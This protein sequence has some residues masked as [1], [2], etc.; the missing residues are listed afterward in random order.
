MSIRVTHCAIIGIALLLGGCAYSDDLFGTNWSG[1]RASPTNATTGQITNSASSSQART[2]SPS[3]RSA[4]ATT[5]TG[6]IVGEQAQRLRSDLSRLEP[7]VAQRQQDLTAARATVK[8]DSQAY[9][10]TVTRVASRVKGGTTPGNPNLVAQWTQAQSSLNHLIGDIDQLSRLSNQVAADISF[11]T[12]LTKTTNNAFSLQGAVEEDH[13]QLTAI[14][15]ELDGTTTELDALLKTVTD[16]IT[17]QSENVTRGTETL[18][19]LAQ[20]IKTGTLSGASRVASTTQMHR[21][22]DG[23]EPSTSKARPFVVIHFKVANPK[24]VDA[25]YTAISRALDRD[26]SAKFNLV[27]VSPAAGTADQIAVYSKAARENAEGVMRS[28]VKMGLP[29]DRLTLSATTSS[30][31]QTNEVRIYVR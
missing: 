16:E 25:L 3:T 2:T 7:N 9:V 30:E 6:T 23:R 28:L 13:R 31:V 21:A 20:A 18:T 4:T 15:K 24:Y 27:A 12:Y 29:A 17:Q 8:R 19:T 5:Q 26:P 10:D 14:K 1:E 11:A 22:V